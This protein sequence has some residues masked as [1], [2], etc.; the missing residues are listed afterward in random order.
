M[1]D[2]TTASPRSIVLPSSAP[3]DPRLV[4][5]DAALTRLARPASP[6][7]IA[8]AG[9]TV[10]RL[11]AILGSEYEVALHGSY[12]TGTA[13][14]DAPAIDV[15]AARRTGDGAPETFG[16]LIFAVVGLLE[17]SEHRDAVIERGAALW[18]RGGD[19]VL[20]PALGHVQPGTDRIVEP[21]FVRPVN[22]VFRR[23]SPALHAERVRERDE[24]T[25][26]RMGEFTR[27]LKRWVRAQ[28]NGHLASG[29]HVESAVHD[30]PDH[31]FDAQLTRGFVA[32]LD[33][34]CALDPARD[35]VTSPC[36]DKDIFLEVE[37]DA[38]RFGEWQ[39]QLRRMRAELDGVLALDEPD[40]V[41]ERWTRVLGR[42]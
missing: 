37:W 12:A 28:G 20:T 40:E 33:H 25:G 30:A 14:G 1:P 34:L 19:V 21:L 27:L 39:G 22:T 9:E 4:P 38:V 11:A 2:A 7:R 3:T 23:M 8:A 24:A 17:R 41:L 31:V 42:S 16:E 5:H 35:V 15:V 32:L 6:T 13:S 26:G 18:L 29:Y 36:G 10:A